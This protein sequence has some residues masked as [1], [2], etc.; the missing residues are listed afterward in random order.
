M[1]EKKVLIDIVWMLF[2]ALLT[3]IVPTFLL[4]VT[5]GAGLFFAWRVIR[6][7]IFTKP[8]K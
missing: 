7:E 8:K 6:A 2:S 1:G 5:M 4:P 3:T